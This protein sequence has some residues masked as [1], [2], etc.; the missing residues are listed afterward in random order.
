[1]DLFER[2]KQLQDDDHQARVASVRQRSETRRNQR[3]AF[4]AQIDACFTADSWRSSTLTYLWQEQDL[5]ADIQAALQRYPAY[6]RERF[7]RQEL[8]R[9]DFFAVLTVTAPRIQEHT[10]VICHLGDDTWYAWCFAQHERFYERLYV[11]TRDTLES[12]M[13][14]HIAAELVLA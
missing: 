9:C 10:W 13:L 3:Q 12:W 7:R 11:T 2:T 14:R 6:E 1:M 5:P 8:E 4:Q